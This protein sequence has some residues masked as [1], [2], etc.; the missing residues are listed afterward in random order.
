V[1]YASGV[2]VA[3]AMHCDLK[4]L[5]REEGLKLAEQVGEAVMD[6]AEAFVQA[7]GSFEV[8]IDRT[9]NEPVHFSSLMAGLVLGAVAAASKDPTD[10]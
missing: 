10:A 9:G 1:S 2:A 6:A 4:S 7:H 8:P 5:S 3:F